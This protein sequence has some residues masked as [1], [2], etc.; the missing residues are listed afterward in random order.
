[1]GPDPVL[2][3][4]DYLKLRLNQSRNLVFFF[5]P[6]TFHLLL[7]LLQAISVYTSRMLR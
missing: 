4:L 3:A 6:L 5:F 7:L 2:T 1:M